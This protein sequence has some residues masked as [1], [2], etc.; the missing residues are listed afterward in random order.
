MVLGGKKLDTDCVLCS[1]RG[2]VMTKAQSEESIVYADIGEF[3]RVFPLRLPS[4]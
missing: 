1:Y 4:D 2:E 3:Y